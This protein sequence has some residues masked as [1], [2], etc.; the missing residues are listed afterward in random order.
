MAP[1]TPHIAEEIWHEVL[2]KDGFVSLERFPEADREK[3]DEGV[4]RLE[5]FI[6]RVVEDIKE[7]LRLAKVSEPKRV[8][9]IPASEWKYAAFKKI[10]EL[11]NAGER[12][13]GVLMQEIPPE[14]RKEVAKV[15]TSAIKNPKRIPEVI[16][17]R[18]EEMR[19]LEEAREFLEREVGLPVEVVEEYDHPKAGNA[20]P[21]KPAVVVE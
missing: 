18:E 17:S 10:K 5:E 4:E 19:A 2:G 16:G 3:I 9:I 15:L 7:V 11:L 13:V 6:Q 21:F 14:H 12:N 20:L 1:I 8:V